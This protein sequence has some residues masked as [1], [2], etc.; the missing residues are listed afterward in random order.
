MN[1]ATPK[2]GVGASALAQGRPEADHAAKGP[3]PMTFKAEGELR[4]YV[5]RS[6]H[7]AARGS[8]STISTR[9]ARRT[10]FICPHCRRSLTHL[11]PVI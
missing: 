4:G 8:G 6:P 7:A 10:G 9:R 2:F 5:L 3:S 11:G 1:I